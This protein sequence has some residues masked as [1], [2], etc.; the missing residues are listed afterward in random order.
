MKQIVLYVLNFLF[1]AV[2]LSCTVVYMVA[3]KLK[4][5][6]DRSMKFSYVFFWVV[7]RRLNYICRRFGT[8]YLFHLHRQVVDVSE[9]SICSIFIGRWW[10]F[11][12]TLSVQSS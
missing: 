11:R 9:H 4:G 12:S 5:L 8:L 7:P 3:E 10:T 6:L 1:L 2:I